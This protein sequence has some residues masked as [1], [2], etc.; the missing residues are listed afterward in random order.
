MLTNKEKLE[1]I[2]QTLPTVEKNL[3]EIKAVLLYLKEK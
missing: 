1:I 3:L 2:Y